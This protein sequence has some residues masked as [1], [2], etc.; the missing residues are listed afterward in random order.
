MEPQLP[1]TKQA[2]TLLIEKFQ[3][4]ALQILFR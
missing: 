1:T 3:N 4:G 2:L